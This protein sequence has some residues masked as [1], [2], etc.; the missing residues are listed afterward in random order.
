VQKGI[1]KHEKTDNY[2]KD[3]T[4]THKKPKKTERD[5]M[6]NKFDCL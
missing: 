3:R 6:K 2:Q 5:D 1:L 4:L